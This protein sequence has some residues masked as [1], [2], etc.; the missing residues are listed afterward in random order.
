MKIGLFLQDT[1]LSIEEMNKNFDRVL[2]NAKK[3]N[4]D[5]LVFPEHFYCPDELELENLN[6]LNYGDDS[7]N[8]NEIVDILRKY[9]KKANCPIIISRSDFNGFIYGL[10]ISPFEEG[11]KYYGKHIATQISS[12]DLEDYKEVV[13]DIFYPVEYKGYN[14]GITICYDSNN[15]LFSKC[16]DDVDILINL[17][18]G[19]VDYKKWYIYQRSRALENKCNYLCTM[20]YYRENAKM[21]HMYLVLMD[22]VKN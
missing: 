6:Y 10:F 11:I 12:F 17:T 9:A 15:L 1:R 3:N 2:K 19:H 20:A 4:L 22:M 18:G 21:I 14:I 13:N 16:Y 8:A 7:S 5:L